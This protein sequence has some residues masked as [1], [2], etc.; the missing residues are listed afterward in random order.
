MGDGEYPAV[1]ARIII[2]LREGRNRWGE[3]ALYEL[4][5]DPI[6]VEQVADCEHPE[7]DEEEEEVDMAAAAV[8]AR[9]GI[10]SSEAQ[11]AEQG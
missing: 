5:G 7:E 9:K 2:I 1:V 10:V 11:E 6:S 8:L 3:L 4:T